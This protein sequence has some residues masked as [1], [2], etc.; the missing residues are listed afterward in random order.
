MKSNTGP[1]QASGMFCYLTAT[2]LSMEKTLASGHKDDWK[3]CNGLICRNRSESC[4]ELFS[5]F[6]DYWLNSGPDLE[7]LKMFVY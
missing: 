6:A 2:A 5:I 4:R 1:G 7:D 3:E